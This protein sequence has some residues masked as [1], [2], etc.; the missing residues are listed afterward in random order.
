MCMLCVWR[1]LPGSVCILLS[2]PSSRSP[3]M[4][5]LIKVLGKDLENCPHFFLDFESKW[6][7]GSVHV[8]V[9]LKCERARVQR[10]CS[11]GGCRVGSG[12]GKVYLDVSC[13][14]VGGVT[15]RC[16]GCGLWFLIIRRSL[17][18]LPWLSGPLPSNEGRNRAFSLF[19]SLW[20][21]EETTDFFYSEWITS[22]SDL[23]ECKCAVL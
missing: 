17:V 23:T 8:S 22:Y 21:W 6:A 4:G 7:P 12:G 3:A 20:L 9:C 2:P 1:T 19:C 15:E 5:N 16:R 11:V 10:R 14:V 18:P 13:W